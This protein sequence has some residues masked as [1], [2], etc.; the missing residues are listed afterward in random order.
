M[1][2]TILNHCYLTPKHREQLKKLGDV[3]EYENTTNEKDALE[4]LA[5]ADA[6]VVDMYEFPLNA[7]FFSK[8]KGLKYI[9][10]NSTGFNFVDLKATQEKGIVVSNLPGFSTEAVAEHAIA[11]MF[12]VAH[13]IVTG[14]KAMREAPFQLNPAN[15]AHDAYIGTN[16]RGKTMGIIGLGQ[17]GTRIAELGKG[18]GMKV[19][20][21][22][23]SPK[24]VPDVSMVELDIVFKESDI[25]VIASA[26]VENMRNLINESALK[27]MRSNAIIVN[28]ARGEFIDEQALA[29]SLEEKRIGGLGADVIADWSLKNPLLKFN[30]VV[31]TPHMAFL[32]EESLEN[33]ANMIVA[34]VQAYKKGKP[35][36]IVDLK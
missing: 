10:L 4:R 34:N 3:V 29:K 8:T 2:T 9:C 15:R 23:R 32:A 14:D 36:N 30:N 20:A 19:I 26:F 5:G 1:K 17:I 11:L 6:A 12:A 25:I 16:V 13:N 33:M 22:N 7:E 31:L 18:L 24:N 35:I 28:I 21:Y 27:K